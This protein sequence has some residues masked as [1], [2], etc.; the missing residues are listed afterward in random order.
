MENSQHKALPW[1]KVVQKPAFQALSAQDKYAAREEYFD[2]V[3]RPQLLE[4]YPDVDPDLVKEEFYTDTQGQSFGTVDE[5]GLAVSD[6]GRILAN[7]A[8]FNLAD[9]AVAAGRAAFDGEL[10]YAQ[11]LEQERAETHRGRERAGWAG[12]AGDVIGGGVTGVGLANKGLTLV[13]QKAIQNS[14]PVGKAVL[15]TLAGAAEG[16]AY[17][18]AYAIGNADQGL[19]PLANGAAF[20]A[21]AIPGALGGAV[22]APAAS[23]LSNTMQRLAGRGGARARLSDGTALAPNV[24]SSAERAL[25]GA[26]KNQVLSRL[27]DMGAD[28]MALNATP[29]MKGAALGIVAK[30]GHGGE[31]IERALEDQFARRSGRLFAGVDDAIGPTGRDARTI[32]DDFAIGRRALASDYDTVLG[33]VSVAPIHRQHIAETAARAAAAWDAKSPVGKFLKQRFASLKSL[34]ESAVQLRNM[35]IEVN[36]FAKANPDAKSTLYR[37]N[38][39]IDAALDRATGGDYGKLQK[40]FATNRSSA[41]QAARGHAFL[42]GRKTR[43]GGVKEVTLADIRADMAQNPTLT[44][45]AARA[46]VDDV[47]RSKTNELSAIQNVVG[48]TNNA[49]NRESLAAIFGENARDRLAKTVEAEVRKSQDYADI[50]RNSNTARKQAAMQALD[51]GGFADFIPENRTAFG[52][53]SS[54]GA[55]ALRKFGEAF[56]SRNSAAR[57]VL[58]A[59]IATMQKPEL[60]E[61]IRELDRAARSRRVNGLVSTGAVAGAANSGGEAFRGR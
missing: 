46:G 19:D 47:M 53:L 42:T 59:R 32:Q 54:L 26:N 51:G 3:V 25:T 35:K 22:A 49:K 13:G 60:V 38:G 48:R 9:K 56:G 17:G 21:G 15:G 36:A 43:Q 34:P 28:A 44:R 41:E 12:T 1:A 18:G 6:M 14:G 2:E 33:G 4:F 45:E 11:A 5:I 10:D 16:A 55:I 27:D 52:A 24:Q 20:A 8:T 40:Q 39:A 29:D 7:A 50:L 31:V 37:L 23:I 61:L 58:M 30:G 57:R